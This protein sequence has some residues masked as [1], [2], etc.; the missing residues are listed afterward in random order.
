MNTVPAL[1]TPHPGTLANAATLI[2]RWFGLPPTVIRQNTPSTAAPYTLHEHRGADRIEAERFIGDCFFDSFGSRIEAFMP[3]LFSV[4]NA[5]GVICGAFGLRAGNRP[6]FLEQYLD[7]PIEEALA[8][9]IGA[10]V[11]RSSVIE[12]GHFSGTFPGAVRA[13][14]TLL[15]EHLHREG[16]DWVVFTGTVGLRNAF[17]RLGLAPMDLGAADIARLPESQHAAWGTYYR[18][19]PRV[20]AGNIHEGFAQMQLAG[21]AA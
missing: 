9:H 15:T 16:F 12:V 5:D 20:L 17:A 2:H 14:I 19:A 4:R 21:D 10:P 11:V 8:G 13:M 3:R 6:L 7:A 1:L 18:H